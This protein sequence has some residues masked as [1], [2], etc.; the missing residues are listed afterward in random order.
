MVIF[1]NDGGSPQDA[2]CFSMTDVR[3][4]G[5][6]KLAALLGASEGYNGSG[7]SSERRLRICM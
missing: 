5:G 6:G 4:Q 7:E 2:R 1:A 3:G